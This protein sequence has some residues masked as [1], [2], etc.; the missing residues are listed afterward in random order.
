MH[1]IDPIQA[2]IYLSE[3]IPN[4]DHGFLQSIVA[5]GSKRGLTQD[6]LK[7]QARELNRLNQPDNTRKRPRD[8]NDDMG[9]KG[10][11][12]G[13]PQKRKRREEKE[14]QSQIGIKPAATKVV[15]E[16]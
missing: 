2:L 15:P 7:K 9:I 8:G 16:T 12:E 5:Y 4:A 10:G 3:S 6:W 11:K 13:G 1:K 14:K